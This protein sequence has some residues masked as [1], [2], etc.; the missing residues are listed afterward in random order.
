[1]SES[2]PHNKLERIL[3]ERDEEMDMIDVP[4]ETI[5]ADL[6]LVGVDGNAYAIMGTVREG[7]QRAGNSQAVIDSYMEQSQSSDYNH[8]LNVAMAFTTDPQEAA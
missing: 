8:L 4:E 7:L 3:R 1:M 5:L 2:K 6:S